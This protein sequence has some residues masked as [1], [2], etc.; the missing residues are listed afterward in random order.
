MDSQ[1]Y[2]NLKAKQIQN[3]YQS[4]KVRICQ[5]KLNSLNLNNSGENK[6]F[7]EF[8]RI[9]RQKEVIQ[10]IDYFLKTLQQKTGINININPRILLSGYLV[11]HYADDLLDDPKN[12]H[13]TDKSFL[14]WSEYLVELLENNLINTM[15][16]AKKIAAYLNNYKNIFDQW[17]M[18]DKNKTIE[19]IIISFHN[20]SEHLEIIQ[21]DTKIDDSQKKD[22]INELEKQREKLL[23][24]IMLIDPNF[25]TDYLKKNYKQI[26]AELKNNWENILKSTGNAMKKAYYDMVSKE[27]SDGNIKPTYDMFVEIYKRILLITPEKRKNSLAEKL[28]PNNLNELLMELDWTEP[29]LNHI[30][31]LTDI[32]LMFSAPADDESNKKWKEELK[33]INQSDFSQKLPQVLIQIEEKLDQIYRLIIQMKQQQENKK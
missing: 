27:L 11:K 32:I 26:Y 3:F 23:Y 10:T 13:P 31:M 29:L 9:I 12:R 6:K 15:I 2:Q 7:E 24:D 22:M 18:M 14:E 5:K 33:D 8:T 21:N 30:T 20:R 16:E 28:D 4:Y 17:K 1:I 25:D 19:R